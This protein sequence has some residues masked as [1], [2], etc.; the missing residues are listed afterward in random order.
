M[1]HPILIAGGGLGGLAAALALGRKGF[2]VRVLLR[3]R[4]ELASVIADN[5]LLADGLDPGRLA[6]L[7]YRC[8]VCSKMDDCTA[9]QIFRTY[10]CS[11]RRG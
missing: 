8:D 1:S 11:A 2:D 3:S 9:L 5:P 6:V 7:H 10:F 4:N